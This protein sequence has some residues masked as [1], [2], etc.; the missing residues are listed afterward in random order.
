MKRYCRQYYEKVGIQSAS[1]PHLLGVLGGPARRA[2][3]ACVGHGRD[4]RAPDGHL[5]A[6]RAWVDLA[7]PCSKRRASVKAY[8]KGFS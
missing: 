4:S 1:S 3:R 2:D 8:I 6:N 5:L 7:L